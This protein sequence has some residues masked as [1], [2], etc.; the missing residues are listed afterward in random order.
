MPQFVVQ[1]SFE[2]AEGRQFQPGEIVEAGG[3]RNLTKLVN[4]RFLRTATAD[5]LATAEEAEPVY[6]GKKKRAR[7][8]RTPIN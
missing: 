1:K 4:T 7:S 3:W 2:G 8:T 5:E 6:A